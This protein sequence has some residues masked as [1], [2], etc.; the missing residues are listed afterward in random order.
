MDQ[1]HHQA[2]I[3]RPSAASLARLPVALTTGAPTGNADDT[4]PNSIDTTDVIA[5][6]A[7]NKP[8]DGNNGGHL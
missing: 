3:V 6:I 7:I 2:G 8:T 5:A 4:N 1:R